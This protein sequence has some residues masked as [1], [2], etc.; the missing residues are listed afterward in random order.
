MTTNT[1]D[2]A[3][4]F[5]AFMAAQQVEAPAPMTRAEKARAK[6]AEDMRISKDAQDDIADAEAEAEDTG[7]DTLYALRHGAVSGYGSITR[8]GAG[9]NKAFG[10]GWTLFTKGHPMWDRVE[11]ERKA[12]NALCT[13]RNLPNPAQYWSNAKKAA[14]KAEGGA[15]K[16]TPEP[17]AIKARLLDDC[18]KLYVAILR[19]AD[20]GKQPANVK[21]AGELIAGAIQT[22]GGDLAPLAAQAK[23]ALPGRPKG[24]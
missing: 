1:N 8:Y 23:K 16:G 18:S 12:F 17:R 20:E 6:R 13:S 4:M 19:D 21:K 24:S 3:A 5:A 11:M 10:K 7:K 9:L 14:V 22:L 2:I 15:K